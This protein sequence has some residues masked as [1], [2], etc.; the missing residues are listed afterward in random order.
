[1][2]LARNRRSIATLAGALA[3]GLL[4]AGALR[5][6]S[7]LTY[8]AYTIS[9]PRQVL[10]LEGSNV[11][12]AWR[13]QQGLTLYPDANHYPYA[14]NLTGPAYFWTVG[15]L[16][17]LAGA[18]VAGLYFLGRLVSFACVLLGAALLAVCLGRR[19]GRW[20]AAAAAVFA[21]GAAPMVSFGVMVRS[22]TL[23]QLLG[24]AGFLLSARPTRGAL[25]GASALLSLGCL[26]KQTAIAYPIAAVVALVWH[27]R[28][29][30]RAAALGLLTAAIVSAIVA[31]A[32]FR[33]EPHIVPCLLGQG[34]TPWTVAALWAVIKA[35]ALRA[36][37]LFWFAAA[38][39]VVWFAGPLRNRRWLS[40][41]IVLPAVAVV[42]CAKVGADVNYFLGLCFVEAAAVAALGHALLYVPAR[43]RLAAAALVPGL[44]LLLP[45]QWYMAKTARQAYRDHRDLQ[46]TAGRQ[47]LAEYRELVR[48]AEDPGASMFSAAD[49][50]AVHQGTRAVLLD[51]CLFR[52]RVEAGKTDPAELIRRLQ[53]RQF[54]YVVLTH[55][56]HRHQDDTWYWRLPR[57]VVAAIV[58]QYRLLGPPQA[59]FFVYVPR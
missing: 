36:P 4:V 2:N 27:D 51:S 58:Q 42:T 37:D 8:A 46:T 25:L 26:A 53:S 40:L 34:A 16:G 59:G 6:V 35:M 20:A 23:A 13:A 47:W 29:F 38:G 33:G 54:G 50:V 44:L 14:A 56:I 43:R 10:V 7:Y 18:D 49:A 11:Y 22:D 15:Q 39:S 30:V 41:A 57:G 17:R 12:F 55:N 9:S 24:L 1:M 21:C 3:A 32:A 48:L 28:Q 19:Y 45:G 31:A 5:S 52:L